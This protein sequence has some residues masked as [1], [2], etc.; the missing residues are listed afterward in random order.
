MMDYIRFREIPISNNL[1]LANNIEHH[2]ICQHNSKAI[3]KLIKKK[4][5]FKTRIK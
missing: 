1:Y 5:N 3:F 4:S 2:D